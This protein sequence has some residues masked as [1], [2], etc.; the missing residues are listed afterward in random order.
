MRVIVERCERE[1]SYKE[2]NKLSKRKIS[3]LVK[4]ECLFRSRDYFFKWWSMEPQSQDGEHNHELNQLFQGRKYV[5]SLKSE[6]KK[7]FVDW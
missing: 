2:Y 7:F 4:C 5:E 3:A 1:C 6:E